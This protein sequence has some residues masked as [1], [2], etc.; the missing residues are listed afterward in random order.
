MCAWAKAILAPMPSP[1]TCRSRAGWT[2]FPSPTCR[3]GWGWTATSSG[4]PIWPILPPPVHFHS[5]RT[6]VEV[7]IDPRRPFDRQRGPAA[8]QR[9]RS[10]EN[11]DQRQG[12]RVHR[13]HRRP[14]GGG[15]RRGHLR[16]RGRAAW[17]KSQIH[18]RNGAINLT[19]PRGAGFELQATAK[20]GNIESKLDLPVTSAGE[21]QSVS[22]KVGGGGPASNWSPI[23]ATSRSPPWMPRLRLPA[24]PP[25]RPRPPAGPNDAPLAR[26]GCATP[27]SR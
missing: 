16:G 13:D 11:L 14:A 26:Q 23:T 25:S 24:S 7:I 8:E 10:G 3:A 9:H 5:S 15:W 4:I 12:C 2:M 21:G 1:A 6:N 20:N 17:E 22:G 18:N 27:R 19:V